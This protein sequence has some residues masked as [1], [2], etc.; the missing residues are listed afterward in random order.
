MITITEEQDKAVFYIQCKTKGF[1]VVD[2]WEFVGATIERQDGASDRSDRAVIVPMMRQIAR[3]KTIEGN[4]VIVLDA[5]TDD[6]LFSVG[7]KLI[8]LADSLGKVAGASPT[9]LPPSASSRPA[10][11]L[12]QS[13]R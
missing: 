7:V 10:L 4:N 11:A 13:N 12:A 2:W 6:E 9:L 5:F 8:D 3:A 1:V